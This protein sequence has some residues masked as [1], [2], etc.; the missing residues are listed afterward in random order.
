MNKNNGHWHKTQA[1]VNNRSE[2]HTAAVVKPSRGARHASRQRGRFNQKVRCMTMTTDLYQ[3][4]TDAIVQELEKGVAPWV[5][6]W[7]ILDPKFGGLPFNGATKRGY[8][9]LRRSAQV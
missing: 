2:K 7:R 1:G 3:Q 4:V 5:K 6:P 9:D 8:P